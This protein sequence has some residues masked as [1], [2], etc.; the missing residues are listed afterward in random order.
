M[1]ATFSHKILTDYITETI[2]ISVQF[3]YTIGC[4]TT[5]LL[6]SKVVRI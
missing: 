1:L 2:K 4:Y 3:L 6:S 5:L